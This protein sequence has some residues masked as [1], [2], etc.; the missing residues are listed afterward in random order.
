MCKENEAMEIEKIK[1]YN[2]KFKV[3]SI[4]FIENYIQEGNDDWYCQ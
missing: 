3:V 2:N 4:K 1:K